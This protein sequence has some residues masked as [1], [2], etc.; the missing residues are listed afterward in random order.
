MAENESRPEGLPPSQGGKYGF[1]RLSMVAASAAQSAANVV[2]AGTKEIASKVKDAGYDTRMNEYSD[3]INFGLIY[4]QTMDGEEKEFE[5]L[6]SG[7]IDMLATMPSDRTAETLT[8]EFEIPTAANKTERTTKC[9]N[10]DIE[11]SKDKLFSF[12]SKTSL[13]RD[14]VTVLGLSPSSFSSLCEL[15]TSESITIQAACCGLNLGS[16]LSN[17]VLHIRYSSLRFF[18]SKVRNR[19]HRLLLISRSPLRRPYS[20]SELCAQTFIGSSPG[21]TI[22]DRK[23]SI[24]MIEHSARILHGSAPIRNC[25]RKTDEHFAQYFH[26]SAP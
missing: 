8:S 26:E 14:P 4:I 15:S 2:Q 6:P 24:N 9:S 11:S 22:E 18:R 19:S 5:Q 21:I 12:N 1:G 17:S 10:I 23:H 25:K 3:D 7:Q 20:Y 13:A 16:K